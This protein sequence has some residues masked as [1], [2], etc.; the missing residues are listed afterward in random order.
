[1]ILW[2]ENQPNLTDVIDQYTAS[3]Q[4][5]ID[6]VRQC[7]RRLGVSPD[8]LARHDTSKWGEAE[9]IPYAFKFFGTDEQKQSVMVQH[10]F[11]RAWLHHQHHNDHHWQH[12]LLQYDNGPHKALAMPIQATTEMVADWMG[13]SV[14]YTGS[15]DMTEWLQKNMG[16]IWLH[17]DTADIVRNLLE[18][19][20][21][22]FAVY[23]LPFAHEEASAPK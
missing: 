10:N 16:R 12:W 2:Y 6:A 3:L 20:G 11:D 21:Y 8:R 23:N 15:D 5:H 1:M 9:F 17:P 19:I 4:R 7:G 13:A 22:P 18:A 14:A